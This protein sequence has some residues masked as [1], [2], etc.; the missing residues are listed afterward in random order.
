MANTKKFNSEWLNRFKNLVFWLLILFVIVFLQNFGDFFRYVFYLRVLLLGALFLLLFPLI[1]IRF[2]PAIL[3]N[4]FVLGNS[5]GLALTIAAA[6]TSGMG[7]IQVANVILANAHERFGLPEPPVFLASL[8]YSLAILLALPISISAIWL[9]QKSKEISS[10]GLWMGGLLGTFLALAIGAII[11]LFKDLLEDNNTLGKPLLWLF[12]HA[13]LNESTRVGYIEGN[14]LAPE[15]LPTIAFVLGVLV[16]YVV[17]GLLFSPKFK[18]ERK[19]FRKFQSPALLYIL[20]LATGVILLLGGVAFLLDYFLI[21]VLPSILLISLLVYTRFNVDHYYE[22]R[23]EL[24]PDSLADAR[25]AEQEIA[26]NGEVFQSALEARLSQQQKINADEVGHTLV[27]VCASGGGIQAAGWSVRVLTGLREELGQSFSRH[28]GLISSVSGGSVGSIYYLDAEVQA[29]KKPFENLAPDKIEE[30][31]D[32]IFARATKDSL[33]ATGWGLAYLDCWRFIGFPL[34]IPKKWDRGWSI[35]KDWKLE[36]SKPDIT[37]NDWR[38][39]IAAGNIP[40]PVFNATI[41]ES[42][43]RFLITPMPFGNDPNGKSIDFNTL[44]KGCDIDITTAARLSA[45]FPYVTPICRNDKGQKGYHVADGGYFDNYGVATGAEYIRKY[46]LSPNPGEKAVNVKRIL[47]LTID[48]FPQVSTS[49]S[50]SKQQEKKGWLMSLAGPILAAL[51]VHSS[52]Q[53]AQNSVN[54]EALAIE[55]KLSNLIKVMNDRGSA[56]T[57]RDLCDCYE[58]E[59]SDIALKIRDLEKLADEKG[60]EFKSFTIKFPCINEEQIVDEVREWMKF[61]V[62]RAGVR[63]TKAIE[64]KAKAVFFTKE[65]EYQPPLS[66]KLTKLQKFAIKLGWEIVKSKKDSVVS[67]IKKVWQE[68]SHA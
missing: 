33:D 8:P 50:E 64:E 39:E 5:Y 28:I 46:V 2:V 62:N 58:S 4:L 48:A 25:D 29:S 21:P 47:L 30:E 1:A 42:G 12:N 54:I 49:V 6:A 20:I 32:K 36:L 7:T 66:W 22:L 27:V 65:G 11:K 35:E 41:V 3:K 23:G 15:Q 16:V 53:I 43:K 13:I 56:Q 61:K 45:T 14:Q 9:S 26:A 19:V 68:W 24:D 59:K 44:F 37:L 18:I 38:G 60:I 57:I 10:R 17:A 51:N 67:D 52:T 40:V 55:A 34:F 63:F 31:S